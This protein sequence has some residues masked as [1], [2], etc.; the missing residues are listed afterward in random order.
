[1]IHKTYGKE[2]GVVNMSITKQ[3]II[4]SIEE[5]IPKY[6]QPKSMH[7]MS[8]QELILF[9]DEYMKVT[10]QNQEVTK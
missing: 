5:G 6:M 9:C 1:M 10:T 3:D 8:K 2:Q 7:K 4:D